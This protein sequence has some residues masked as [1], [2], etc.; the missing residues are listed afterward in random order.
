[1]I[2][3]TSRPLPTKTSDLNKIKVDFS[4]AYQKGSCL[5]PTGSIKAQVP[6]ALMLHPLMVQ[7]GC[8]RSDGHIY[9]L[10]SLKEGKDKKRTSLSIVRHFWEVAKMFPVK[11]HGLSCSYMVLVDSQKT[12]EYSL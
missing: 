7:D 10:A 5:V 6:S 3:L 9:F 12:K 1:M 11:Y 8:L 4:L 2:Q